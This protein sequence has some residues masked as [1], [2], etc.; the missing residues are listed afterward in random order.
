MAM[1]TGRLQAALADHARGGTDRRGFIQRAMA[2]GAGFALADALWLSAGPAFAQSTH[3]AAPLPAADYIVI[4]A[5]SSGGTLAGELARRSGASVLVLEGGIS[6]EIPQVTDPSQWP[7]ALASP[8]TANYATTP[9]AHANNRVIPYPRGEGLGGCSSVNCM[10]YARG[11]PQDYNDWAYNGATGWE[12]A[13]V[14]PDFKALEDWQGGASAWRGA[15]GPLHITQPDPAKGHEGARA[16]IEGAVSLGYAENKDFNSGPLEGPAWVN[17]NIYR[18]KRQ[19]SAV[20]FLRPAIDAGAKLTVFTQAPVLRLVIEK[21]RCIGVEYLH[22]GRKIMVRANKEV[23]LSAG[24]IMTPK[25]LTLSGLG[26]AAHLRQLGITPLVDLPGVGANLQDHV[27]GAGVNFEGKHP[28]PPSNY[29]LS[30][31]YMWARSSPDQPVPD[32]N[33][34]YVSVPFATKEL[35]LQQTDGYAI[36]CGVM[37]PKSRGSVTIA[38]TDPRA[39]PLIDPNWLAAGQDMV[40]LKAATD[41]ARAIGNSDAYKDIRKAE[42]LPGTAASSPE[43]YREFLKNSVS[44]YFHPVGTAK[45]GT[46][47]MAVV[48]PHLRVYGVEG[49]RVADA[50]VMPSITTG[51]T[52]A[53]SILIGY[54]GAKMIAAG[55]G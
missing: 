24:A 55:A 19:N 37:R 29:N 12:W 47:P 14:L 48:D 5:G 13:S 51:N 46:D 9:Q 54:R 7:A 31:V 16:F 28:V 35:N 10:I 8:F 11:T 36:L 20:A 27:L 38:S 32:I 1:D 17:F 43:T 44:T 45:M 52:N 33:A 42:L 39:A 23:I 30:E 15:G 2:A 25:I 22:G 34:L 6:D 50:S 18:G 26:D 4:G 40:A 49:L 3:Q 53:P 41:L 21:G